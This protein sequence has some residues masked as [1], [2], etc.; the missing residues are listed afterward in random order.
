MRVNID[1]GAVI[2]K[3][4]GA[5]KK[6]LPILTNEVM[7]DCNEFCKLDKGALRA[8]AQT[9][10]DFA[11]GIVRWNTPYAR[12]QYWGIP[13]AYEP[14]TCWQWCEAAKGAYYQRWADQAQKLLEM[15][16]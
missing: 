8:S 9:A 14:G 3:I 15:N 5:W 10:T 16:L 13:T 12:R 4:N 2:A 11:N 1:E 6:G 7:R